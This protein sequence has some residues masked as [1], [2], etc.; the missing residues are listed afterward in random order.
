VISRDELEKEIEEIVRDCRGDLERYLCSGKILL[1]A[2]LAGEV[3]NDALLV[4]AMKR[5]RGDVLTNTKAY[6]FRVARNAAID[7]LKGQ[8][9]I[10]VPDSQALDR[11]RE[12]RDQLAHVELSEDLRRAIKQLPPRQR[13]VIELRYLGDFSVEETARILGVAKGTVGPTTAD[14]LR[15]LKRIMMDR[16][17]ELGGGRS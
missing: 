3:I 4:I 12:P 14:A 2:Y 13:Q 9:A 15:R 7:R 1:P 5:R 6:L 10:T 17:E 16:P 8:Y 11:Y